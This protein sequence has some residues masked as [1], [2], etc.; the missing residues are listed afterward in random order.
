MLGTGHTVQTPTKKSSLQ[1]CATGIAASFLKRI[2]LKHLLVVPSARTNGITG[3]GF[4]ELPSFTRTTSPASTV[5]RGTGAGF[6]HGKA[7]ASSQAVAI[8]EVNTNQA[9]D[10]KGIRF[11]EIDVV[12][13]NDICSFSV[14]II[15]DF[16]AGGLCWCHTRSVLLVF[17]YSLGRNSLSLSS[18]S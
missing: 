5:G 10:K 9:I 8:A 6:P 7:I 16:D 1:H 15:V 13:N 18:S 14:Q 11:I 2:A 12:G 4:W 3:R 17:F